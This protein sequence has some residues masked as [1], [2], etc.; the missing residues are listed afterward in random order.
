MKLSFNLKIKSTRFT[1][2]LTD[3]FQMT[4]NLFINLQELDITWSFLW[5]RGTYILLKSYSERQKLIEVASPQKFAP[6]PEVAQNLPSPTRTEG[7]PWPGV[8]GNKGTLAKYWREQGNI[9]LFSG[10]RGTKLYR[11]FIYGHLCTS[12]IGFVLLY[13][14]K[15]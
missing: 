1:W 8:L 11:D 4:S 6:T 10:N 12:V 9:S 14:H 2:R 15:K 7:L 13:V 5:N 3:R